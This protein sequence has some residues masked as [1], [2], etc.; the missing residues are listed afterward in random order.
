MS[1]H[2]AKPESVLK[3]CVSPAGRAV[4]LS[5]MAATIGALYMRCPDRFVR[6]QFWA[7][8]GPVLFTQAITGGLAS[9]LEP[10]SGAL[11][12]A[13]RI[14]ALFAAT[15]FSIAAAPAVYEV[16]ATAMLLTVVLYAL[17]TRLPFDVLTRVLLAITISFAPVKN[18]TFLNLIN[19]HWAFCGL[20]LILLAMSRPPRTPLQ[21]ATDYILCALMGLTGP[22]TL[23]YSPLFAAKLYFN[24]SRHAL[25]L[26]LIA[27][28]TAAIQLAYLPSREYQI[29]AGSWDT[30]PATFF[31]VLV[32]RFIWMIIGYDILPYTLL[33]LVVGFLIT[34]V[35]VAFCAVVTVVLIRRH[36][37]ERSVPI[38]ACALVLAATFAQY[39]EMPETLIGAARYFYIP[40]VTLLWF[41]IL[42]R[43]AV[44][45]VAYPI[46]ASSFLVFLRHP[47]WP[48]YTLQDLH[49][50]QASACLLQ[51]PSCVVEINP[52]QFK[53]N[54]SLPHPERLQSA[55]KELADMH[56]RSAR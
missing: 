28:A 47:A 14:G 35:I 53:F 39:R 51:D 29:P 21:A 50:R 5:V 23:I 40:I 16:V 11:Y 27:L 19:A 33:P 42:I 26:L 38:L 12:T 55:S 2:H 10:I 8:D 18:E 6:P 44:P 48:E 41:V 36:E 17:S 31:S 9:L 45:F 54:V 37:F 15:F 25:I 46:L 32:Y 43:K 20:G 13:E 34:M 30:S 1:D 52:V 3:A 7:E 56:A 24:R 49:W 22:F 4:K